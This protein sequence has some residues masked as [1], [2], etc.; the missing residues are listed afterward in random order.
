M[1]SILKVQIA[2]HPR[3]LLEGHRLRERYTQRRL[4]AHFPEDGRRRLSH[5]AGFAI[6]SAAAQALRGRLVDFGRK[7]QA[8]RWS[9][10]G[11][12]AVRGF[13]RSSIEFLP[14]CDASA[15]ISEGIAEKMEMEDVMN[16][17]SSI[18]GAASWERHPG[19]GIQ[20]S[21][22]LPPQTHHEARPGRTAPPCMQN[23]AAALALFRF[24]A[25]SVATL[26]RCALRALR[27]QRCLQKCLAGILHVPVPNKAWWQAQASMTKGGLGI[28]DPTIHPS[29]T[30]SLCRG[31]WPDFEA[32]VDSAPLCPCGVSSSPSTER[33][34]APRRHGLLSKLLVQHL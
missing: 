27:I 8:N 18:L 4:P 6:G 26:V 25:K 7:I 16:Q 9:G 11:L 33:L 30:D 19:N 10:S 23:P 29:S 28:R 17:G 2:L 34:L 32:V 31:I 20:D 15:A 14:D 21:T 3:L 22:D 5:E 1:Q 13:Y 12:L 24:C